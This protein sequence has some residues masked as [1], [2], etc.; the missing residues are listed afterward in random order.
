M[1]IEKRTVA[2]SI[3]LRVDRFSPSQ[4]RLLASRLV[5]YAERPRQISFFGTNRRC[6]GSIEPYEIYSACR[7]VD[8]PLLPDDIDPVTIQGGEEVIKN[9]A[10]RIG[11]AR[12][13]RIRDFA[14][15]DMPETLGINRSL[16]T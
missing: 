7:V 12:T 3:S 8:K 1:E 2:Q 16:R 14:Y 11:Q 9:I 6:I 10:V 15:D 13:I 5:Q 4:A